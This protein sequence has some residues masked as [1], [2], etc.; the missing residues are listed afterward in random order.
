MCIGVFDRN[1]H[2]ASARDINISECSHVK[3]IAYR[4]RSNCRGSTTQRFTIYS[5][6]NRNWTYRSTCGDC[7]ITVKDNQI[8]GAALVCITAQ[9]HNSRPFPVNDGTRCRLNWSFTEYS[10]CVS[11][12]LLCKDIGKLSHVFIPFQ[13]DSGEA[14]APPHS[15]RSARGRTCKFFLQVEIFS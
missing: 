2:T 4:C 1:C 9:G 8:A 7:D 14:I 12:N 15:S 10:V 6:S 13:K 5:N 3:L 11:C